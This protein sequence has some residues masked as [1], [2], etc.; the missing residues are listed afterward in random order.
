MRE[1]RGGTAAP[2]YISNTRERAVTEMLTPRRVSVK[3][4]GDDADS[5]GLY[6]PAET[7]LGHHPWCAI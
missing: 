6:S 3:Q 5:G 2:G 7:P 4:H 1:F